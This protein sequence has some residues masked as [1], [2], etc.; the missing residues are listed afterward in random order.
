VN[1]A[2]HLLSR[3]R[4]LLSERVAAFL[5]RGMDALPVELDA[6]Q[7]ASASPEERRILARAIEQVV[8]LHKGF[9]ARFLAAFGDAFDR[10]LKGAAPLDA[11]PSL[12]ELTLVD[13]AAIE[14]EIALGRLVRKTLDEIDPADL[15]GIEVRVGELAAGRLLES[16]QNPAGVEAV[17]EALKTVCDTVPEDA[18][19]RMGL[20]NSLQP[21]AAAGLRHAYRELNDTLVAAGVQPKLQYRVE[22]ARDLGG[23]DK[24]AAIPSGMSVSQA[25][26]LRDLLPVSTNTMVDIAAVV[27]AML[28]GAPEKRRSGARILSNPKG[29]LYQ[30]AVSTPVDPNLLRALAAASNASNASNA[31][32]VVGASDGVGAVRALAPQAAHPLDRLT[33]DLVANVFD[34]LRTDQDLPEPVRAQIDRL[35]PAAF[36]AALVDR[37]FFANPEHP[38]RRFLDAMSRLAEDPET[39]AAPGGEFVR[40][41]GDAVASISGAEGDLDVYEAAADRLQQ[42][43]ERAAEA[44]REDVARQA[45]EI[46]RAERREAALAHARGAVQA[47]IAERKV[48]DFVRGFL[49]GPW[50]EAIARSESDARTGDDGPDRRLAAVDDVLWSI[51]PRGAAEAQALIGLL[52]RLVRDLQRGAEETMPEDERQRFFD[53]LMRLHTE[54]LQRARRS[55]EPATPTSAPRTQ[56]ALGGEATLPY[57]AGVTAMLPPLLARGTLVEIDIGGETARARLTWVSPR[58]GTYLF[59]SNT[60]R[61]RSF[62]REEMTRML[63]AG[64]L[65]AAQERPPAAERAIAAVAR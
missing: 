55:A 47:R 59:T 24:P 48:P 9:E 36:Q 25:L 52:P 23:A 34:H 60:A 37:S 46:E 54:Q 4:T 30:A 57:S 21:H 17:L 14:L 43:A 20:A 32:G 38:A 7:A 22:R 13:D 26:N 58:G 19:V 29:M 39:D 1:P 44:R 11:R 3:V 50:A 10:R 49:E 16:P 56:L 63:G 5:A 31:S 62:S 42:A 41:L 27:G 35:T 15:Y 53:G 8:P 40:E 18:A 28:Q 45:A 65:R 6:L 2:S 64:A 51:A 61:A 33:G 12:D